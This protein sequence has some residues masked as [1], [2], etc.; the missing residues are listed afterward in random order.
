MVAFF[1]P[2]PAVRQNG[3]S[4]TWLGASVNEST[5]ASISF[6]NFTVPAGGGLLVALITCHADASRTM[7]SVSIGGSAAT[8]HA[9]HGA[10]STRKAAIASRVVAAGAHNV[11]AVLSGGNGNSARNF[12]GC[13]LLTG[14][15]SATPTFAQFFYNGAGN[16][17]ISR[18]HDAPSN[19]VALYQV[20]ENGG[21]PSWSSAI[22]DGS[23]AT[24]T[25]STPSYWA[26]REFPAGATGHVE[27]ATYPNNPTHLLMN[28]AVWA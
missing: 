10:S 28:A 26:S 6:G 22:Q 1:V 15:L 16:L 23:I 2:P 8:L 27:T 20:N 21:T 11:S 13:W 14:Y 18:T 17:S 12:C 9:T 25:Y 19:A 7:S 3:P 5:A 4:K 24:P